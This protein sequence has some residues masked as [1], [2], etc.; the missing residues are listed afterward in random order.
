MDRM[1]R[2]KIK[3]DEL[4]DST[5]KVFQYLEEHPKPFIYGALALVGV[6]VAGWSVMAVVRGWSGKAA[7][8]LAQGIAAL[9]APIAAAQPAH[10]DDPY[11]PTF[12]NE[13]QRGLEAAERF[14]KAA[15]AGGTTGAVAEYLRGVA[16]L[17]GGE[18]GK[19]V[20]A[21]EAACGRLKDDVTLGG[22]CRGMLARAY[23]QSGATDKAVQAWRDLA[24]PQAD[25]PRD[26]ALAELGQ[27]LERAGKR[28]EAKVVFKE[29]V[30]LYPN[31]PVA[32]QA[33]SSLGSSGA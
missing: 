24:A 19:A 28:E 12:S 9:E 1:D 29:L 15:R 17:E 30:D 22:P 23:E 25:F 6:V 16:L 11:R 7:D 18:A 31:S 20:E 3:H 21:L 14:A 27:T 33:K 32:A 10:P 8:R 2:K 5:M 26:L 4:V 13:K